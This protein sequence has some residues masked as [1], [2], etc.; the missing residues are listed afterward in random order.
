MRFIYTLFLAIYEDG[1]ES[2]VKT[3]RLKLVIDANNRQDADNQLML[4]Q[5]FFSTANVAVTIEKVQ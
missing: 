2:P 1:N 5:S 3:Y 4:T